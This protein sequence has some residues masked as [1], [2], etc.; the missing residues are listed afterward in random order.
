MNFT[1]AMS[2]RKVKK[3]RNPD[4]RTLRCICAFLLCICALFAGSFCFA[5]VAIVLKKTGKLLFIMQRLSCFVDRLPLKQHQT[6]QE[7]PP[8]NLAQSV[9][10]WNGGTCT[11]QVIGHL[12][13]HPLRALNERC[14]H[15]WHQKGFPFSV[16]RLVE[17]A[18]SAWHSSRLLQ[19]QMDI[20]WAHM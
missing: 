6:L 15:L 19:I 2:F 17:D 14:P 13:T 18:K 4:L 20:S 8:K 11:P 3:Y 1:K 16:S 5:K 10:D 7:L 9:F 12:A